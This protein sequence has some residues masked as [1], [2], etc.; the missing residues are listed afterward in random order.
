MPR[1]RKNYTKDFTLVAN[2]VI[3]D[4]RLSYKAR[5]IFLYLW[6]LPDDWEISLADIVRHSNE[7]GQVAVRTGVAEL[8]TYGYLS[9]ERV[10]I[11]GK[12]V[13]TE[14]TITERPSLENLKMAS[15]TM[16]KPTTPK[17]YEDPSTNRVRTGEEKTPPPLDKEKRSRRKTYLPNDPIEQGA[18]YRIIVDESFLK[19][20]SVKGLC[21]NLE[22]QWE[23][24]T[25][26]ALA[27][28]YQ[29]FN[30]RSA[31][32][33]WLTSPFQ[34][35][36]NIPTQNGYVDSLSGERIIPRKMVL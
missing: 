15:A 13:D 30:W 33:N 18:L 32:Q 1:L 19:W 12:F 16:E 29:Y 35:S 17:Y 6:H 2:E 14:W 11:Q 25:R 7:D 8:E 4:Q 26:K 3:R 5:G 24:F 36:T 9:F 34:S 22:D 21:L 31:F 20:V 10:R 28:G 27:K 23:A